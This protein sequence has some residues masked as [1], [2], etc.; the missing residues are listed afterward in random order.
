MYGVAAKEQDNEASME[1]IYLQVTYA[2]Q[3]YKDG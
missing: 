1:H 2:L 3:F